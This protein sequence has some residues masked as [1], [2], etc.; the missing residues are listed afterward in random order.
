MFP[1]KTVGIFGY[2]NFLPNFKGQES[3]YFSDIF[4]GNS[5]TWAPNC[6]TPWSPWSTR[7]TFWTWRGRRPSWR[8]SWATWARCCW[9][10]SCSSCCRMSTTRWNPSVWLEILKWLKW[11]NDQSYRAIRGLILLNLGIKSK[12]KVW[13]HHIGFQDVSTLA[14]CSLCLCVSF[15]YFFLWWNSTFG[16]VQHAYRRCKKIGVSPTWDVRRY[17]PSNRRPRN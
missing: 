15:R 2:H 10:I 17:R 12:E 1:P 14:V 6:R 11:F 9:R 5:R 13:K 4:Q 8:S 3:S 7:P 16:S